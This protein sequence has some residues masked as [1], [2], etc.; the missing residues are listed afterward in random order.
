MS[1]WIHFPPRSFVTTAQSVADHVP[2]DGEGGVPDSS[3]D[4]DAAFIPARDTRPVPEGPSILILKEE[5]ERFVGRKVLR[6]SGN[7]KQD[8]GRMRGRKVV[9]MRTWGKHF[10]IEFDGFSLRI[11]MM[12]FGRHR[13]NE[14]KEFFRVTLDEIAQAVRKHHGEFELTR[15]AEAAEYRKTLALLDE[16]RRAV[17]GDPA[18]A[19]Q[20]LR[21]VS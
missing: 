9:G 11:H 3:R 12:M 21:A 7:S 13:I 4:T 1:K 2:R 17:S 8:I 10:L 18:A 14:R 6:V 5:A 15:V 19:P 20:P 16:E